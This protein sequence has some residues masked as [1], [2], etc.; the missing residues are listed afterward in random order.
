MSMNLLGTI[1]DAFREGIAHRAVL[2]RNEQALLS[3][4]EKAGRPLP[5]P[6]AFKHQLIRDMAG[7]FGTRVL[8]ETGTNFGHTV[9]A[10]LGTFHTIYSIELMDELWASARRRFARHPQ[11]KLSHGDSARELPRI[12]GE[13]REPALFWLDAHYSGAGTA[14]ADIDTPIAQELLAISQHSLKN[15]VLLIDDARKFDGTDAYP[16][17]DGCRKA[18]AGY[19]PQHTFEV[20]DD[21]IRIAPRCLDAHQHSKPASLVDS[22]TQSEQAYLDVCRC[23]ASAPSAFAGFRRDPGYTRML[24]HVTEAQ[25]RE[26]LRLLSPDGRARQLLQEAAKNDRVGQPVT[27]RLES[28]LEMSPTTLRYLKVADDIERLFGTLDGAAVVEIGV[29][30]GGQCRLLDAMFELKSY[31][32]VDLRPV[33]DLAAEFLSR[34]PLRTAVR[35]L[36]MNELAPTPYGFAISNYAFTELSRDVQEIY[37]RKV[38]QQTPAGYITYNDIGPAQLRPLSCDELCQRLNGRSLPE[39]PV[40]HPKNRLIVWGAS[41]LAESR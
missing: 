8:V 20:V 30:Y 32:L 21:V 25:G 16:T 41:R 18:A 36:T 22:V 11:V 28:G 27:M 24:E 10:V 26:Y 15:H 1:K 4:W 3:Q 23:A 6:Q 19:W 13:L 31:T 37:Y 38:L 2:R 7:R 14:R 40:T 9:S 29:G 17:L 12:L 34:F 33:L 39:E 35:F 5:P